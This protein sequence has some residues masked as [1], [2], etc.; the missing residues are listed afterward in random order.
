MKNQDVWKPTKYSRNNGHLRASRNTEDVAVSSRLL[1]DLLAS[2]YESRL[3]QFARGRLLDLGCGHVPLYEAYKDLVTE[4]TCVDWANTLH[5]NSYVDLECD[6]TGPIPLPDNSF[7]TVILSDV[8]EHVP[9]P[10]LLI[11]EVGRLLA[12]SGNALI[13]V[14]FFYWLHEDPH[15]YYRYTKFALSRFVELSGL[16][17]IELTPIGGVPEIIADIFA[18]NVIRLPA[19]GAPLAELYQR[20]TKL[21]VRTKLGARVSRSTAHSF[22]LE[23]FLIAQ[24]S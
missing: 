1:V 9:E 12:P 22:P 4:I 16:K 24:K 2:F 8:L 13:S 6:L 14:P 5:R 20:L 19:I 15:D 10:E 11:K 3:K 21:I 7:D 18:K 23:Y 17:V